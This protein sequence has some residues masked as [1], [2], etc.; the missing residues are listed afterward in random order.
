MLK[1]VIK[2]RICCRVVFFEEIIA[3]FKLKTSQIGTE[4]YKKNTKTSNF[5]CFYAV[6]VKFMKDFVDWNVK[7]GQQGNNLLSSSLL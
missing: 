1:M 3:V 6:F 4:I 7:K 5:Q 2:V